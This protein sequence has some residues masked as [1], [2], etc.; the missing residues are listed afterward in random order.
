MSDVLARRSAGA[1]AEGTTARAVDG[2]LGSR[3]G[4]KE[5]VHV[6]GAA[7]AVAGARAVAG[8]LWSSLIEM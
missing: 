6:G 1:C 7:A 4:G 2:W 8:L 3:R 5:G